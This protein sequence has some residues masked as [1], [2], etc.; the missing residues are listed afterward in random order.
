MSYRDEIVKHLSE[1]RIKHF[2]FLDKGRWDRKGKIYYFDHILPKNNDTI[3]FNLLHGYRDLFYESP[4]SEIK[5]HR[6]FHHLNSSQAMCINFFFP[7]FWERKLELVLN[8]IGL[9]DDFV[10]YETVCFEKESDI[11]KSGRPTSFDFYFKTV[12]SR[13]IHF[14]IKYTEYDFAKSGKDE[15]HIEKYKS[16]YFGKCSMIRTD[17]CNVDSFLGNYQ[18][19]RNLIHVSAD[20]YVI[21]LHP[22]DNKKISEEALFAKNNLIQVEF[23]QYVID[24]TWEKLLEFVDN[25]IA[26]S[27]NLISQMN[28][29]KEK[30]KIKT[31]L[32]NN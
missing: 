10:D 29:F 21:L 11:E 23:Q 17:Y 19:M 26:D 27:K 25:E 32:I 12:K 8:A 9:N 20:S 16:D 7:L 4:L 2:G 13:K 24:L 6:F 14:E 28:E 18:L 22:M 1:Y 5:Y 31:C 3:R 15:E 30:Y